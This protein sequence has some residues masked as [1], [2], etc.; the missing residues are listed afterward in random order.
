MLLD[1]TVG[2]VVLL[3]L[4]A[5]TRAESEL[6]ASMERLFDEG[7]SADQVDSTVGGGKEAEVGIATGFRIVA[8]ENVAAERPRQF[9]V[10]TTHQ[11]CLNAEVRMQTEYCLS[12]RKRL[13]CEC[14]KQADLLKVRDAEIESLKAQLLLKETKVA[15][16]VHLCAQ[17][18]AFEVMEKRH[19]SEIDAL[20]QKNLAFENKKGSID[21][22]VAELQ[23]LVSS[24]DLKLKELNVVVS[25]L[26]S[27]KDALGAAISR[28]IK[29]GMQDGLATRMDHGMEGRS[30][31]DV[32]AYNPSTEADF[33]FALQELCELDYPLL[34][35]LKSHKDASVEVIMNLLCLEGPLTD[36]PGM[37]YLQPD[38]EQLKVPI[39]ISEDQVVLGETSLSFALSVSHSRVE[40]IRANIAAKRSALLDVWTPLS[41]PLFVQHLIGEVG[42]SA[43]VPASTVTTMTLSIIS[44]SSIPPIT[45]DDYEIVHADGLESPQGNVQGDDVTVE[46]EKEDLDTTP[47][48]DLLS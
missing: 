27:Q 14:D 31:T 25:S 5:P 37:G 36:A 29:K 33:N 10:G 1:S 23:S 2:R 19:A 39:H 42:T 32:A 46:F 11:A 40:Q 8:E 28:S 47:E 15:K 45:V 35:E 9:N 4:V 26:M 22:K 13:E 6:E 41:E 12:E 44:V 7:G 18:S 48:H 16:A 24:K 30:L 43:S 3:L 21:E 38:I 34:S 20:K 17:V